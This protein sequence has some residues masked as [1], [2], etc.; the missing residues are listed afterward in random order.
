[1]EFR[2]R[3]IVW[4]VVGFFIPITGCFS[5]GEPGTVSLNILNWSGKEVMINVEIRRSGKKVFLEEYEMD[6][7]ATIFRENIIEGGDYQ[8]EATVSTDTTDT[9]DTYDFSM[10]NCDDQELIIRV[11]ND[12]RIQFD[13]NYCG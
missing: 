11:R 3:H 9:T 7:D 10:G 2:R 5:F 6:R 12:G 4:S 13:E 8:V 1:M